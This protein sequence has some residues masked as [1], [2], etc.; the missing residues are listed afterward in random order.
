MD[1]GKYDEKEIGY[2]TAVAGEEAVFSGTMFGD[3]RDDVTDMKRL[4]KKQQ[5]KVDAHCVSAVHCL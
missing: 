2:S 5:F 3:H 1:A 4:G